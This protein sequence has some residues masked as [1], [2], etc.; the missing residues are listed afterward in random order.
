M[1]EVIVTRSSDIN[2][3]D[4]IRYQGKNVT[5]NLDDKN[6]TDGSLIFDLYV[7]ITK[8]SKPWN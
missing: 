8:I 7:Y 1:P 3:I 5:F 4:T 2:Q 6:N